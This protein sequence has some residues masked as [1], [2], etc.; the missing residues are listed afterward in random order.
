[1][2]SSMNHLNDMTGTKLSHPKELLTKG[3]L[4]GNFN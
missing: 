2:E 3:Y 4:D 1:M